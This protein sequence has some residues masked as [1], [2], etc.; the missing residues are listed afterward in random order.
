MKPFAYFIPGENGKIPAFG[1][2]D[3][4]EQAERA[5]RSSGTNGEILRRDFQPQPAQQRRL[6]AN[7]TAGNRAALPALTGNYAPAPPA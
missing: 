4:E 2:A 5:I 1:Q 6:S 7:P 3:S